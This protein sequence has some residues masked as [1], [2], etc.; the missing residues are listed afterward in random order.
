MMATHSIAFLSD[1]T[2][3]NGHSEP[4][5]V[6]WHSLF[7]TNKNMCV[8]E[9]IMPKLKSLWHDDLQQRSSLLHTSLSVVVVLLFV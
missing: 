6:W 8:C 1:L 2:Q 4:S 9:N 5:F 3:V 7:M